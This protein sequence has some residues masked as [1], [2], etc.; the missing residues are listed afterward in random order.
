[1]PGFQKFLNQ[2]VFQDIL[3]NFNFLIHFITTKMAL[4]LQ[5]LELEI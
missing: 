4:A 1:M 3:S 5:I 2:N